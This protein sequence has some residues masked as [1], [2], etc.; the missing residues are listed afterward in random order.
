M[1]APR[2]GPFL[3]FAFLGFALLFSLGCWQVKRLHWKEN[4]IA[5][6]HTGHAQSLPQNPEELT[7]VR[8]KGYFGTPLPY[9][10]L[11]HLMG[12]FHQRQPGYHIL[13]PFTL[14]NGKTVMVDLGWVKEKNNPSPGK[15]PAV[16]EGYVRFP[17]KHWFT[18]HHQE[19]KRGGHIG[20]YGFVDLDRMGFSL[21][22]KP[23][24]FY[25]QAKAGEWQQDFPIKTIPQTITLRNKHLEYVVTWFS[26][27]FTWLVFMGIFYRRNWLR[28]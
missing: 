14:E 20:L 1:A 6:L 25:I 17:K 28:G 9:Y 11:F 18:P 19:I 3:L 10:S 16:L 23:L 5:K 24:P 15:I 13:I 27:A 7:F 21:E 26:L 22:T 12:R 4:L 2:K 8:I